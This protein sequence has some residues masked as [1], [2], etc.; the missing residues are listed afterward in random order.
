MNI[1]PIEIE[2]SDIVFGKINKVKLY[3]DR[4]EVYRE[5]KVRLSGNRTSIA[6]GPFP[7][8][9]IA[10]SLRVFPKY[11]YS[12][13]VSNFQLERVFESTFTSQP[14]QKQ[15]DLVKEIQNILNTLRDDLSVYDDQIRF[16]EGIHQPNSQVASERSH[17]PDFWNSVLT[18]KSS[19]GETTREFRRK[20][21][22]QI[23]NEHDRVKTK[24][25]N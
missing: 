8:N 3:S 23:Q 9:L 17:C 21:N 13:Q 22:I 20:V 6:V 5:L 18:F 12:L 14:I 2:A 19:K 11:N 7:D 4:A 24:S 16:I 10:N 1:Q 15:N 25:K